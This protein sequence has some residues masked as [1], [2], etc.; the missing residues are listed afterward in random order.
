MWFSD[1]PFGTPVDSE[2]N[3]IVLAP[4][5]CHGVWRLCRALKEHLFNITVASI[6]LTMIIHWQQV[7]IG[8]VQ[9]ILRQRP[10]IQF[11]MPSLLRFKMPANDKPVRSNLLTIPIELRL[12]IF[13]YAMQG[14]SI[15]A[16][17]YRHGS[18]DAFHFK[19]RG[20]SITFVEIL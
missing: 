9:S 17:G 5:S 7:S 14:T 11:R 3:A 6:Q 13:D 1:I 2:D 8:L 19:Q 20:K 4:S 12:K 16:V 10:I 18:R 15:K